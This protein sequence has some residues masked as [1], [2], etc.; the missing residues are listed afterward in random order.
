M[1]MRIFYHFFICK[2]ISTIDFSIS[3][4]DIFVQK[5]QFPAEKH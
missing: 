3:L 5:L 2:K 1:T 4:I